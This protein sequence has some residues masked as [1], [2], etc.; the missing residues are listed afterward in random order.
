M[1]NRTIFRSQT[2]R[3]N[4]PECL[5][6]ELNQEFGFQLDVCADDDNAKCERYYTAEDDGLLMPWANVN[7]C[8]PPYGNRIQDWLQKALREQAKGKTTVVL[9]PA[10]TDTRWFHAFV[11][12]QECEIRFIKGRLRFSAATQN[13]PF[14]SMLL[15]YKA[16]K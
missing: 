14:A 7:W 16:L 10:R 4:T 9:I 8:N 11:L 5:F 6:D 13:A 2:C 1:N 12:G 15:I 3:W